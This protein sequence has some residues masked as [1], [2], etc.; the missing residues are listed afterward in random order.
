VCLSESECMSVKERDYLCVC[1]CLS[2]L[3]GSNM[4]VLLCVLLALPT[5]RR[6]HH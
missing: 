6:T 3:T 2:V 1:A 5:S 4:S